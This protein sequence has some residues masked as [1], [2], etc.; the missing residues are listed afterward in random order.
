V[1]LRARFNLRAHHG[2]HFDTSWSW[3]AGDPAR[4]EPGQYVG[5]PSS[6]PFKARV[7][8]EALRGERRLAEIAAAREGQVS[9]DD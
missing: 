3:K 6:C 4:A 1:A 9:S 2:T 5:K 7:T 8:L